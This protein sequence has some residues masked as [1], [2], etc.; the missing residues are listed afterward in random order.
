MPGYATGPD[1]S[2]IVFDNAVFY[3][4]EGA[5]SVEPAKTLHQGTGGSAARKEQPSANT[6]LTTTTTG[7]GVP[8][9]Y[10]ISS[11]KWPNL[12]IYYTRVSHCV[13]G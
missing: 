7:S 10:H 4:A 13:E 9:E 12:P 3:N 8:S 1:K 5:F 2:S 6:L 11:G